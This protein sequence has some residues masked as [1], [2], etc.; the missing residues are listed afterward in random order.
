MSVEPLA[1]T[2]IAQLITTQDHW[3]VNFGSGVV[4]EHNNHLVI[5][6]ALMADDITVVP[7]ISSPANTRD[8]VPANSISADYII[9]NPYSQCPACV[10]PSDAS[11]SRWLT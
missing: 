9:L 5:A 7:M 8:I 3:Y 2:T 1:S 6:W 11:S 4:P 10:R